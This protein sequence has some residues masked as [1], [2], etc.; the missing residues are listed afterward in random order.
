MS[1]QDIESFCDITNASTEEA[2]NFLQV[3]PIEKTRFL[4]RKLILLRFLDS[5]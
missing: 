2:R 1:E 4:L 5:R 3:K